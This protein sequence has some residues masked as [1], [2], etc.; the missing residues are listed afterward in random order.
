V[1]EHITGVLVTRD[2][3]KVRYTETLSHD[4]YH[5]RDTTVCAHADI[6]ILFSY[7]MI[8]HVKTLVPAGNMCTEASH[9]ESLGSH[10]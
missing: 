7:I 8:I 6:I 9:K 2:V 10:M 1:P 4:I 5:Y 3:L